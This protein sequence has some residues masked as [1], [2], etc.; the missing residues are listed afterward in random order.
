MQRPSPR[1]PLS[2]RNQLL[3]LW[4]TPQ[5]NGL[6]NASMRYAP[7]PLRSYVEQERLRTRLRERE[8]AIPESGY[9]M[10]LRRGLMQLADDVGGGALGDYLE[11]GVFNGTSLIST[12]RETEALGLDRMRLFGFDSFQGLPEA[13]AHDDDGTWAP[14]AWCSDLRFTE[15]VLQAEGVDRSRVT[16]IPGWFNETCVAATAA[17]H[18]ISKASVIMIDCDIYSST[19]DAL[20]FCTPLIVDEALMLFDDWH[21]GGLAAKNLGERRAFDEWLAAN[22]CFSAQPFGQYHAKSQTY[23]ITRVGTA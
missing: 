17:A 20:N 6:L 23:L 16:L 7:A 11:F 9:R 14:G 12:W 1:F 2:V 5:L 19:K 3:R 15:A 22:G 13:A 4:R 18:Q 10:L 8:R 21:S